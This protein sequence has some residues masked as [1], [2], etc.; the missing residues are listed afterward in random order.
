MNDTAGRGGLRGDLVLEDSENS[1]GGFRRKPFFR[2]LNTTAFRYIIFAAALFVCSV[3]ILGYVVYEATIGAAFNTIEAELEA[4]LDRLER[5]SENSGAPDWSALNA[6]VLEA[7]SNKF[8]VNSRYMIWLDDGNTASRY[9]GNL[10]GMPWSMVGAEG[11]F[12]FDRAPERPLFSETAPKP[13]RYLGLSRTLVY[14]QGT[15]GTPVKAILVLARDIDSL[16]QLRQTREDIVI[17]VIGVTLLLAVALGAIL[18]TSLV[19]RLDNINRSVEAITEGDLARRLPVTGAGDEFD[20]LA[21]N[22]NTMLDQIEQL[23]TGMRQVSDNIAHD[24]RSPLTRIKARLDSVISE[25][26]VDQENDSENVLVKTRDEV[27]RLLKTFNALLS[28]TRIEAGTGVVAGT[29]DL[30]ALAEEMLELYIPAADDEGF[31]LVANLE[32]TK[33]VQGS[34]ELISQA[35]ANLLDNAMKYARHAEERGIKPR[36]ELTVAPRPTGG[37]LL[38]IMDNGPG[39]AEADRER[40]TRRFVRLEQSRSTAGNGLGLSLVAAIVRR[41]GGRL[42]ITRG[43]PHQHPGRNLT[44]TSAYGLGIRIALPGLK[45]T[46]AARKSVAQP[47]E[48]AVS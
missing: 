43:L 5:V 18:G 15:L 21:R 44:P 10:D 37:V 14:E 40:I 7:E 6:V 24:L 38:S 20:I 47:A 48:T 42:T 11:S 36:I 23:M 41:H 33:P 32:E 45:P 9:F 46:A 25:T 8:P 12:E 30:K 17:R 29:I 2:A 28:I 16:H 4:E 34:R 19:R 35:I 13:R 3:T 31:D 1:E 22:I 27:E 39:V 26:E